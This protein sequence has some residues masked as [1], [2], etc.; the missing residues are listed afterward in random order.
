MVRLRVETAGEVYVKAKSADEAVEAVR[1]DLKLGG[2]ILE[3]D[4]IRIDETAPQER[5]TVGVKPK[6]CEAGTP[7]DYL[8][9]ES[10]LLVKS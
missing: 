3:R 2:K 10:G 9:N 5:V 1:E 6:R 7:A 8:V 4:L